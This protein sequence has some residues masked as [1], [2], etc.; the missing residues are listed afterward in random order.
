MRFSQHNTPDPTATATA[1][2]GTGSFQLPPT[3]LQGHSSFHH[4]LEQ[5]HSSFHQH[6]NR[7]IPA[8]THTWNKVIPG[9]KSYN[10][11][12]LTKSDWLDIQI[13]DLGLYRGPK[14]MSLKGR[15]R[16]IPD[17]SGMWNNRQPGL[18]N[19]P[20]NVIHQSRRKLN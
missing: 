1:T 9:Y 4:H 6:W 10:A 11:A 15:Y 13:T 17:R 18:A 8:S 19:V 5:G 12:V 2:L 16:S 3:L 20:N 7:I 14:R